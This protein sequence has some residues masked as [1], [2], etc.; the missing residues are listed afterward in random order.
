MDVM[1][2]LQES[3]EEHRRKQERIQEEARVEEERL[4]AEARAEQ[5]LPQNC[6]MAEIEAS[7]TTMEGHV[8][9]NEELCKTNEELR[10]ILHQ[11]VQCSTRERPLSLPARNSPKPFSKEIMDELVPA[12][13]ITPKIAFFHRDKDPKNHLTTFNARMIISGGTNVIQCKMFMATFTGTTLQWFS[14]ILDGQ[15]ASFSQF[16]T[17]FREQ[18]S[19]NKVKPRGYMTFST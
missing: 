3:N 14:G 18:F 7:R 15:I 2:A 1:R 17:M 10:K 19:A 11:R 16:S 9:A 5:E 13:Y 6:L 12:H 4:R 8:Q